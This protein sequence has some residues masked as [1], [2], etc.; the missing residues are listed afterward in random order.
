MHKAAQL[1]AGGL[2]LAVNSCLN[3]GDFRTAARSEQ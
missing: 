3:R 1:L 2:L